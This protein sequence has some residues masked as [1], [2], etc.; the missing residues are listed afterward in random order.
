[1]DYILVPIDYS[2]CSK[3]A[4]NYAL[5]IASRFKWDIL[6]LH[7]FSPQVFAGIEE[8][9]ILTVDEL[10]E[11]AKEKLGDLQEELED[12]SKTSSSGVVNINAKVEMGFPVECIK[13][14]SKEDNCALVIMGSKGAKG[15]QRLLLGSV[16]SNVIKKV[17]IP[18]LLVPENNI[19][20]NF[21]RILFATNFLLHDDIIG[22]ELLALAKLFNAKLYFMHLS[23]A[24][25][26]LEDSV[27][28]QTL[29]AEIA[30]NKYGV[31]LIFEVFNTEGKSMEEAIYSY[32]GKHD[33]DLLALHTL[34]RINLVQQIDQPS[35]ARKLSLNL[36]QPLLIFS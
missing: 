30:D 29:E 26:F 17:D 23:N 34:H 16:S 10:E 13:K 35:L 36:K 32:L 22:S 5:S 11:L 24:I 27:K 31:E 21:E 25:D 19:K 9:N 4:A 1:M 3:N 2:D 8:T 15:L 14:Y 6:L 33:I 20:Y 7:V 18:I 28:M 12:K